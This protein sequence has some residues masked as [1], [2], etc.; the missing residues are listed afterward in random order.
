MR[1]TNKIKDKITKVSLIFRN[2]QVKYK[3]QQ[4]G[5]PLKKC[6]ECGVMYA[7]WLASDNNY[8]CNVCVHYHP[9]LMKESLEGLRLLELDRGVFGG[10]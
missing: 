5:M 3:C 7:E 4:L 10:R 2:R 9:E 8:Y 6:V 1:W